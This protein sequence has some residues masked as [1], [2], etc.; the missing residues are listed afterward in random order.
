MD[1]LVHLGPE[2]VGKLA[3]EVSTRMSAESAPS[4]QMVLNNPPTSGVIIDFA[5]STFS[6]WSLSDETIHPEEFEALW[7]G[8]ALEAHGDDYEWHENLTGEE[9]RT[10]QANVTECREW[11]LKALE[12]GSRPNPFVR[13]AETLTQH[14]ETV[15]PLGT[16][17]EFR[18]AE[19]DRAATAFDQYFD[20]L[21]QTHVPAA[22]FIDRNGVIKPPI[23]Q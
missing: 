20:S 1:D 11:F 7:P 6:W 16:V 12:E 22:R 14:G 9:Y 15:Q 18:P 3:D 13:M 21:M 17:F 4:A 8:W 2:G 23:G 5:S 10:W 19:R